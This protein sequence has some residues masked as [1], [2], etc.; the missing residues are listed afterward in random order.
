M[1]LEALGFPLIIFLTIFIVNHMY[2][3]SVYYFTIVF[4]TNGGLPIFKFIICVISPIAKLL[5]LI[6]QCAVLKQGRGAKGAPLHYS[7]TQDVKN[8]KRYNDFCPAFE[9]GVPLFG[10]LKLTNDII[11]CF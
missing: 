10:L 3:L 8:I 9:S 6:Y 7:R 1:A 2:I 4:V 11:F 5:Q